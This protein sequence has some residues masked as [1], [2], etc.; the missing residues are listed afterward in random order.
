[1]FFKKKNIKEN[2]KI[3]IVYIGIALIIVML[4]INIL[5]YNKLPNNISLQTN[6]NNLVPKSIF[7]FILPCGSVIANY[8]NLKLN[9]RSILNSIALNIILPIIDIILILMNI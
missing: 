2:D 7:I 9:N 3:K 6:G 4:A 5:L 1:M 8:I